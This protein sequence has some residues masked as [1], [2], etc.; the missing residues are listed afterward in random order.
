MNR[1]A[2]AVVLIV[3]ALTLFPRTTWA[4]NLDNG[5]SY[6]RIVKHTADFQL[7]LPF[8]V[9][10]QYD[11]NRDQAISDSELQ[12]HKTE[13]AAYLQEHLQLFNNLR[14]MDFQL[15]GLKS[16]IQE[17]TED[18]MVQVDMT[19]TADADVEKLDIVYGVFVNDVDPSHE[20]FVQVY[21]D[22]ALVAQRVVGKD[23]NKFEYVPG[24]DASFPAKLLGAFAVLGVQHVVRSP[25][26]W[27]LPL[28][29]AL[30]VRSVRPAVSTMAVFAAASLIGF[31]VSFRSG[32]AVPA[33]WV[34]WAAAALIALLA[35]EQLLR[36]TRPWRSAAFA[37]FGLLHGIGLY[38]Y[39]MGLGVPSEYKIIFLAVYNAGMFAALTAIACLFVTLLAPLLRSARFGRAAPAALCLIAAADIVVLLFG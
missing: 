33:L 4:H 11:T 14:Q 28:C 8:P 38:A 12:Q 7:L 31:V 15:R 9:L 23:G 27:L 6:V 3:L 20:N 30:I 16:I 32:A 21:K 13:F 24:G 1:I 26:F 19:F 29:L 39:V 37:A 17:R 5:Y 2:Q 36:Q 10:L 18:P 34:G 25:A 22:G 35:A